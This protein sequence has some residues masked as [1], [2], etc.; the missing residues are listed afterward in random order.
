MKSAIACP[1]AEYDVIIWKSFICL[2][3]RT[4]YLDDIVTTHEHVGIDNVVNTDEIRAC[5]TEKYPMQIF[6]QP[7][8]LNSQK[9][10]LMLQVVMNRTS[11]KLTCSW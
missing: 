9:L 8:P 1:I 11:S 5:S 2:A 6:Q 3:F 10:G 7:D 4:E